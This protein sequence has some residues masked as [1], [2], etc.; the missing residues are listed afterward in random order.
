MNAKPTSKADLSA[1]EVIAGFLRWTSQ[2]NY[3]PAKHYALAVAWA[4]QC[5]GSHHIA[6]QT[7]V[8]AALIAYAEREAKP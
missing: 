6:L 7:L 4:W 3:P 2:F 5:S 8:E 1:E